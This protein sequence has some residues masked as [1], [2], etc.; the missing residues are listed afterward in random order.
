MAGPALLWSLVLGIVA[1]E[2]VGTCRGTCQ[3]NAVILLCLDR[4]THRWLLGTCRN[5]SRNLSGKC[6][7]T[8]VVGQNHAHRRLL[9][10][11]RNLSRILSPEQ[12]VSGNSSFLDP[13]PL[14][15]YIPIK[16]RDDSQVSLAA[17]WTAD[18]F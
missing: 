3:G 14:S 13:I 18:F 8:I 1:A 7:H 15:N 4:T 5:L 11:C 2:P 9:G 10:T 17:A 12:E 16:E 6:R